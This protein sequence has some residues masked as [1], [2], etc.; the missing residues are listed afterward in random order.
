MDTITKDEFY[1]DKITYFI[2]HAPEIINRIPHVVGD[3]GEE[4]VFGGI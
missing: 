4:A 1:L 2:G 3:D